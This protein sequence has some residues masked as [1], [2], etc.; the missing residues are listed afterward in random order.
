MVEYHRHQICTQWSSVISSHLLD[1]PLVAPNEVA[2]WLN[3]E[4]RGLCCVEELW[5]Y[6]GI[7]FTIVVL[8]TLSPMPP[9]IF[10]Y[11]NQVIQLIIIF[12][13]NY[14]GILIRP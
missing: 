9:H 2:V 11:S 3:L 4:Q 5:W 8:I 13:M 6:I 7:T 10:T 12:C 14:Y 1:L